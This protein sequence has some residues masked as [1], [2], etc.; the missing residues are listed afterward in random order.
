MNVNN[1]DV[2]GEIQNLCTKVGTG[3]KK[4]IYCFHL[5]HCYCSSTPTPSSLLLLLFLLYSL[6]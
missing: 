4:S 5:C 6:F 3:G 1:E 2:P